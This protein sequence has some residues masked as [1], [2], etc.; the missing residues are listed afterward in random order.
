M[1]GFAG[2]SKGVLSVMMRYFAGS[3][4][5]PPWSWLHPPS[6]HGMLAMIAISSFLRVV[7][8]PSFGCP[9]IL[10]SNCFLPEFFAGV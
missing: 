6:V 5:I 2:E 4:M 1:P 3:I 7:R 10:F 8:S 9:N